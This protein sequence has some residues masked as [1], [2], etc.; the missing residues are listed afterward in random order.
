MTCGSDENPLQS[1]VDILCEELEISDDLIKLLKIKELVPSEISLTLE[2][3]NERAAE[4]RCLL[5]NISFP[6]EGYV[7]L[8][9]II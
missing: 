2:Q 9:L 3:T 6:E 8:Y 7:L 1:N 4:I 5:Q